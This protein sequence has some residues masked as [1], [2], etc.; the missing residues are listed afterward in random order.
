M[1]S[2]SKVGGAE[3]RLEDGREWGIG[4][5][6]GDVDSDRLELSSLFLGVEWATRGND[7]E[8]GMR[9]RERKDRQQLGGDERRDQE[10][11][12]CVGE[13]CAGDTYKR[14]ASS[15]QKQGQASITSWPV[16]VA[17]LL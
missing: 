12:R 7:I 5:N 8:R 4:S 2:R 6:A 11:G 9:E 16:P 15:R 3:L 17:I 1:S 10:K 13:G 14:V